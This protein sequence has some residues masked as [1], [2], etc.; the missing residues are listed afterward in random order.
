VFLAWLDGTKWRVGI[1]ALCGAAMCFSPAQA[2]ELL[3]QRGESTSSG[4]RPGGQG[5]R[6]AER[7]Y[8]ARVQ[9]SG[10]YVAGNQ[11]RKYSEADAAFTVRRN[12]HWRGI[13]FAIKADSNGTDWSVCFGAAT[14]KTLQMG[15]YRRIQ[16][17]SF[18]ERLAGLDIS[19]DHRGESQHRGSFTIHRMATSGD[20][21]QEFFATFTQIGGN[22]ENP[23]TGFIYYCAAPTPFHRLLAQGM[24]EADPRLTQ[25]NATPTG[26]LRHAAGVKFSGGWLSANREWSYTDANAHFTTRVNPHRSGGIEIRLQSRDSS[27]TSWS[28]EFGPGEGKLLRPG[29]YTDARRYSF[30]ERNPGL[31][32]SGDGRSSSHHG[33]FVI[34]QLTLDEDGELLEFLATFTQYGERET[35]PTTGIVYYHDTPTTI[36][37]WAAQRIDRLLPRAAQ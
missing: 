21:I 5:N 1:L 25:E 10:G 36:E 24:D 22:F 17:Y 23:L 13:E 15:H 37:K 12:S 2:F 32:V 31:E 27:Q 4:T 11:L 18:Q 8:L 30:S 6:P 16:R 29:E 34:Q 9:F 3:G 35:A 7:R 33:S 14:G 19:G 26:A 28:F 20:D